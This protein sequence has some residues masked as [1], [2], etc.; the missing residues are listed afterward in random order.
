MS[1]YRAFYEQ[2]KDKLFAYLMRMTGN[3]DLSGEIMQ[4]SFTRYLEHYRHQ[5]LSVPL[6]YTIVRHALF[7]NARAQRRK[8]QLEAN[9]EAAVGNPEHTMMVREEYRR[10]LSAIQ[11]LDRDDREILVLATSGDLSYQEIASLVGL[12]EANVKVKVHRSRLKLKRIIH[13]GDL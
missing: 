6:L 1:E 9:H 7:D 13:A 2:H 11:S 8:T 5:S 4:E 10:V 12:S 3:Y